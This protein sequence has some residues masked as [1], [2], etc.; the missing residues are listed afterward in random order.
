MIQD[1]MGRLIAGRTTFII[2]H[3]FSTI[4]NADQIFVLS[5]GSIV[6]SGTHSELLRRGGFYRDL[7]AGQFIYIPA[8]PSA[9][10]LDLARDK[11][12]ET[13]PRTARPVESLKVEREVRV[14]A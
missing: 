11:L 5:A 7:Y 10:S 2:A 14:P 4:V 3:R 6:E 1:A 8:S 9:N 12:V 13:R